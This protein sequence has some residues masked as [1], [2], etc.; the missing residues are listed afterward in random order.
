VGPPVRRRAGPRQTAPR[1][2]RSRGRCRPGPPRPPARRR[3]A[4]LPGTRCAGQSARP[5]PAR[6]G[7]RPRGHGHPP[8]GENPVPLRGH[9]RHAQGRRGL[10]PARPGLSGRPGGLY[11]RGLPG[12]TPHHRIAP[13]RNPGQG[14]GRGRDP[15]P[16]GRHGNGRPGRPAGHPH[17]PQRDRPNPRHPR[18]QHLYLRDHRPAQGLPHRAPPDLQPRAFGSLGLRHRPG[19]PGAPVR[20]PG[21]RRLPGRD[22]DGLFPRRDAAARHQGPHALGPAHGRTAHRAWRHGHLLRAHAAVHDRR[23]HS[24]ASGA[25]R[26]RRG[27]SPGP[28]RPLAPPRSHDFQF[29]RPHRSHGGRHLRRAHPGRPG[30]HRPSPAQLSGLYSRRPA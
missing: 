7:H 2:V 30:D 21:L 24:D 1:T 29:L 15:D 27:L 23:R 5:C 20:L 9:A 11:S 16:A 26:R 22:L 18:L 4:H 12:Q 3:P 13:G 25:H 8:A 10:R 28:G 17:P 6:Q 14:T 19:R